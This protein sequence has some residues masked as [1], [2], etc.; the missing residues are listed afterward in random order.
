LEEEAAWE[1]S[2]E[3]KG[4]GGALGK[5]TSTGTVKSRRDYQDTAKGTNRYEGKMSTLGLIAL[6]GVQTLPKK[7]EKLIFHLENEKIP[8]GRKGKQKGDRKK[9]NTEIPTWGEKK[10]VSE[11]FTGRGWK[12]ESS[13][14]SEGG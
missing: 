8:K 7:K 9:F 13:R 2:G 5:K 1:V 12:E 4:K 3:G 10:K 11:Q 14:V 6:M